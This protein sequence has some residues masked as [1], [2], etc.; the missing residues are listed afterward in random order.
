[1]CIRDSR[2]GEVIPQE[3]VEKI[4]ASS[5]YG[6]GFATVEYLAASYVDLDLHYLTEMPKKLDVMKFQAEKM[7]KR[8]MPSQIL[9]RYS[10]TNFSHT[11]GGGYSAGYYS[12]I[13]AE[14][15][16]ADAFEAFKETGD[17][18]NQQVAERFLTEVL[19]PGGILP[20]DEM[21]RRFRGRDPK[22]DGLL[23]NRGFLQAQPGQKVSTEN[24]AGN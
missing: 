19:T 16:D 8:G 22:I 14:V 15:L 3:L 2:T 1:M 21:Y 20:G 11:M 7:R 13:W 18:F 24:K 10:V 12:Y 23:R 4:D 9:P 5:K 17:I 6:Q